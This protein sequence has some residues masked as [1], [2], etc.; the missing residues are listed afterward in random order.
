MRL[1]PLLFFVSILSLA[2]GETPLLE[3]LKSLSDRSSWNPLLDERIPRL[4]VL[5]MTGASYAVAGALAQ[6]AFANPLASPTL[7]GI[8]SGG[9]LA[10][11]G[12]F[13]LTWHLVSPLLLPLVGFV[14]CFA[15]LA[16][17]YCLSKKVAIASE[18]SFL[19]IGIALS[20]LFMAIEGG[21]LYALRTHWEFIQ[22]VT[23]WKAASTHFL[24]WHDVSLEF[25]FA[26][27][28]LLSAFCAAKE[29]DLLSLGE[30]EATHLGL[31]AIKTRWRLFA[32]LSLLV[33]AAL[34][35]IGEIPFLGLLIPHI[36]RALFRTS[37][38]ELLP[39]TAFLGAIS[40]TA[41]DLFIRYF[42][43]LNLSI[44]HLTGVGGGLFFIALLISEKRHAL[45]R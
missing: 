28:G 30:E 9:S 21:A 25:P 19:L 45:S 24:S 22:L 1:L 16:L 17:V 38:Q 7:L 44:T 15:V 23:E 13:F 20:S 6:A 5:W 2:V 41:L 3:S 4:L 37:H 39:A 27:V 12:A 34:T 11:M 18:Q 32:I 43:L 26:L 42:P 31:D 8:S 10:M 14:G 40:L 35:T 33:G 36:G 29:I